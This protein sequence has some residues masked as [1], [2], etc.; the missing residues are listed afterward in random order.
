MIVV[1]GEDAM[2]FRVVF[3]AVALWS[4]WP[5]LRPSLARGN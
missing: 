4:S 3:L 5:L 1:R 2:R